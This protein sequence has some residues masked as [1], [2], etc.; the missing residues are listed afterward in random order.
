MTHTRLRDAGLLVL[1]VCASSGSVGCAREPAAPFCVL[2]ADAIERPVLGGQLL[3][4]SNLT[5][6]VTYDGAVLTIDE[7]LH[8]AQVGLLPRDAYAP[9]SVNGELLAIGDRRLVASSDLGRTWSER[10]WRGQPFAAGDR[11]YALEGSTLSTSLDGGI[12]WAERV[13][14]AGTYTV[15]AVGAR[16]WANTSEGVLE[17]RDGGETFTRLSIPARRVL[18]PAPG[19]LLAD[20]GTRVWRSLDGG[21]S[22]T[23]Y[24]GPTI[25]VVGTRDVL[26]ATRDARLITSTDRGDTWTEVETAGAV[27]T[28]TV[29]GDLVVFSDELGVGHV[30]RRGAMERALVVRRGQQSSVSGL[31][32]GG[33]D[34]IY[35]VI[36]REASDPSDTRRESEVRRSVDGGVSWQS[37]L[38]TRGFVAGALDARTFYIAEDDVWRYTDDGGETFTALEDPALEGRYTMYP[39]ASVGRSVY[40]IGYSRG[41]GEWFLSSTNGDSWQE[42]EPMGASIYARGRDRSGRLYA[43]ETEGRSERA[44]RWDAS[45]GWSVRTLEAGCGVV[46]VGDDGALSCPSAAD[47]RCLTRWSGGDPICR[48]SPSEFASFH[49][50]ELRGEIVIAASR[51]PA[52]ATSVAMHGEAHVERARLPLS[53]LTGVLTLPDGVVYAGTERRCDGTTVEVL[54]RVE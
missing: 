25:N 8:A 46:V 3:E 7:T 33:D 6:F 27:G 16:V 38:T 34:A 21:Q 47:A 9:M 45:A 17:S 43:E 18:A 39:I 20:T 11:L 15:T 31:F 50:A 4:V 1:L 13:A 41:G 40:A 44:G 26:Y 19:F 29:A 2:E 32:L 52:D 54:G 14:P 28:A 37:V 22:W 42:L 35:A 36:S 53:I 48:S 23:E 24:G 5:V 12:S 30:V 10:A 51:A 49:W